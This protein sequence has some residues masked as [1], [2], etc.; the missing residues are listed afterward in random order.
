[1]QNAEHIENGCHERETNQVPHHQLDCFFYLAALMQ[2]VIVARKR[3]AGHNDHRV[4]HTEREKTGAIHQIKRGTQ[5]NHHTQRACAEVCQQNQ[6]KIQQCI[7][8]LKNFGIAIM[9]KVLVA[10]QSTAFRRPQQRTPESMIF[11]PQ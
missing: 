7:G 2:R 3:I 8:Q 6:H 5:R 9:H 4:Q 10:F 11:I 1:M